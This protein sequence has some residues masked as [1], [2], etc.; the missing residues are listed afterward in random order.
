MENPP[1]ASLSLTHVHYVCTLMSIPYVMLI[2]VEPRRP[3]LIPLRMAGSCATRLMRRLRN[4]DM[5]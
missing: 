2:S 3:H 5:E 1:L 4:P